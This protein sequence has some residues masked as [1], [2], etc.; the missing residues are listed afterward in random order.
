[1]HWDFTRLAEFLPNLVELDL[2]D[3]H[4]DGVL[5]FGDSVSQSLRYIRLHM[6]HFQARGANFTALVRSDCNV[7]ELDLIGMKTPGFR[8]DIQPMV[9]QLSGR[10]IDLR[11]YSS[12]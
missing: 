9:D 1:M 7:K 8:E 10:R 4:F 12:E 6:C 2:A 11:F 5:D 3:S